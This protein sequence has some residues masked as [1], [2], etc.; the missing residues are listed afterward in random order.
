MSNILGDSTNRVLTVIDRELS[1]LRDNKKALDE[2]DRIFDY[3]T[4]LYGFKKRIEEMAGEKSNEQLDR[5]FENRK[6]M[7]R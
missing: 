7:G 3:Q 5:E 4:L 2:S 6:S 1:V